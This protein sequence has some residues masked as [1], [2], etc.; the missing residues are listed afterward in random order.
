MDTVSHAASG[1]LTGAAIAELLLPSAS[2]VL[3]SVGLVAGL[4][5]DLDFLAELKG[6]VAAWTMHRIVAHNIPVT[7]LLASVM[8]LLVW[9]VTSLPLSVLFTVCLAASVVHLLL[10]VLTSF[11]TCLLYPFNS[12]R[13]TTRSHFIVDPVVILICAAGVISARPFIWFVGVACYLAVGVV[14]RYVLLRWYAD[15][16]SGRSGGRRVQL[17]PRFMAPFRWLIIVEADDG[18]RYAY[19]TFFWRGPWFRQPRRVPGRHSDEFLDSVIAAC[20]ADELLRAVLV[21][22]DMPVYTLVSVQGADYVLV[23]DLK[24]RLEPQLRPMAFS[25]RV[26]LDHQRV[27]LT[28]VT[29]G[30]FFQSTGSGLFANPAFVDAAG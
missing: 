26:T 3:I 8:A 16:F 19:Q 9:W 15:Q 10:D 5:P 27:I 23:E 28:E 18:Y 1:A 30:G 17:E 20:Q 4:I 2:T 6:K 7:V 13:F 29:Q 14:V 24:W 22:F 12:Y 11:G 25:A 21:T